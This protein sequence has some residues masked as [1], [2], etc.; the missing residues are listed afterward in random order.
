MKN[1]LLSTLIFLTLQSNAQL[2][3]IQLDVDPTTVFSPA[4]GLAG[5]A[6]TG[7]EFWVSKWQTGDIYTADAS[8]NMTGNF[9]INGVTGARSITTDGNYMYIGANTSTI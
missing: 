4:T 3:S 1:I 8:G 9:I 2:W 6:W 5:V 7:T